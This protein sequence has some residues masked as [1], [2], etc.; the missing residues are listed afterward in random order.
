MIPVGALARAAQKPVLFALDL[1]VSFG[2]LV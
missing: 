2:V 1:P